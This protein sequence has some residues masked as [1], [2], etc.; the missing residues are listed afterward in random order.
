MKSMK[1]LAVLALAAIWCLWFVGCGDGNGGTGNPDSPS[2][3]GVLASVEAVIE[4]LTNERELGAHAVNPVPLAVKIDGGEWPSLFSAVK[5]K[6]RYV[7]LD[8]SQCFNV[9]PRFTSSIGA[10]Q[11]KYIVSLALPEGITRIDNSGFY[12]CTSL[13]GIALPASLYWIGIGAFYGCIS[14]TEIALPEWM[15]YIAYSAFYG[16]TSL[17][18]IALP[19]RMIDTSIGETTF[20]YCISLTKIDLPEGLEYIGRAAFRECTGLTEIVLPEGLIRISRE[21]FYGCHNLANVTCLAARPPELNGGQQF[22]DT[23]SNFVIRVPA[24]SVA[25]YKAAW[26]EW[27]GRISGF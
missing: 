8:L 16:C 14:L 1:K 15:E 9:P 22:E 11:N 26:P 24:A 4:Y 6:E 25:A 2:D 3:T 18:K 21:A 19:K 20:Y 27:A 17:A 13:A 7:A 12:G 10:N 5:E 23:A